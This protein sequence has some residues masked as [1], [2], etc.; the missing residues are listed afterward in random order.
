MKNELQYASWGKKDN[1]L[2]FVVD[3]NIYYKACVNCKLIQLTKSGGSSI[4]NGIPDWL[5][6]EEILSKNNAIYFS[7]KKNKMCFASFND[8]KVDM[9]SF[10]FYSDESK[11]LN[12]RYPRVS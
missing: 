2:V 1:D 7:Q 11:M 10:P 12:L 9:L 5:Y 8:S 6:E 4:L 3:D